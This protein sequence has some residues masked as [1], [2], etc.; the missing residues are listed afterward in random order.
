MHYFKVGVCDD[1]TPLTGVL[2]ECPCGRKDKI[3]VLQGDIPLSYLLGEAMKKWCD[4]VGMEKPDVHDMASKVQCMFYMVKAYHERALELFVEGKQLSFKLTYCVY[5][6]LKRYI[7][8]VM[9][10]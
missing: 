8:G 1:G 4:V 2:I 10:F 5:L 7:E 9:T 3:C 6:A